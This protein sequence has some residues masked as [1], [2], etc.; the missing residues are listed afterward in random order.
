MPAGILNAQ[1]MNKK[2]RIKVLVADESGT[3]IEIDTVIKGNVSADSIKI[4]SGEVIYLS[5]NGTVRKAKH[6]KGEKGQMFVAV[7][8]DDK[9]D[10]GDKGDKKRKREITVISDDSSQIV[11]DGK[12]Y[13]VIIIKDGKHSKECKGNEVVTWSSSST[14]ASSKAGSK[15]ERY[16]Y[17]NES[18]DSGKDEE[19]AIN[20]KIN[21]DDKGNSTEKT[22]YIVAKDGIV[23][24]IEGNDEA[25][26]KEILKE[27]ELKL[28]VNL[29]GKNPK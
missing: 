16:I 28:G 15:G 12:C 10:K 5:R 22:R 6:T 19:K 27:V 1:D 4:K 29:E 17:I 23:V 20:L 21:E 18:K 11:K 25:K 14:K 13:N 9:G 2:Q 26:A 8:S 24:T 3:K 7:T